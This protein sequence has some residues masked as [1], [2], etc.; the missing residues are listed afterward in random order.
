M[1]STVFAAIVFLIAPALHADDWPQ[2]LGPNRDG[3]SSESG[4]K[5]WGPGGPKLIWS[6]DVGPGFAGPVIAGERVILFHRVGAEE[7]VEC[8]RVDSGK[9]VWKKSYAT[10]FE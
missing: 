7:I 8:L 6:R 3:V 9:P 2:F 1:R 10:S 5:P 4:V